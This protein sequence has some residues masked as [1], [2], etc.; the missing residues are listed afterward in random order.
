M[1]FGAEGSQDSKGSMSVQ[2][3]RAGT[4]SITAGQRDTRMTRW[5]QIAPSEGASAK[6]C[7]PSSRNRTA[8]LIRG[9]RTSL[10]R[11][12]SINSAKNPGPSR[13]QLR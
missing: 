2:R 12:A 4:A 3:D 10:P 7:H 1:R 11:I 13:C 9:Q 8:I 5:M 6:G